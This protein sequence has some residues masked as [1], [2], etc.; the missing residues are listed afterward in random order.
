MDTP[1]RT[2]I[3]VAG[4]IG[5]IGQAVCRH[6]AGAYR[7]IG[8]T[9]RPGH[10]PSLPGVEWRN[11]DLFSMVECEAALEGVDV[12]I[13]LVHSL[14]PSAQL[15]Q[16]TFQDMDLILADNFARAAKKCG[17]SRILYLGGLLP[18]E[19]CEHLSRHLESRLEVERA[20]GSRG[21]PLT[22]LRASIVIGAHGSSFSIFHTLVE[23]LPLIPCP[24]WGR[25]LTQ[26]VALRDVV[27]LFRHCLEHPET[28]EGTFDV[29]SPDV[30]TYRQL[31]ERTAEAM[32][33]RRG[34]FDVPLK[35]SL[36]CK[37]WLHT[38]TGAPMALVAPLVE[39]MRFPMVARDRRLQEAAAIP[40]LSLQEALAEALE[41]ER[42]AAIHPPVAHPAEPPHY[43]VRSVQ[44]LPLPRGFSARLVADVY[45][46]WLPWLFRAVLRCE[47]DVDRDVR[48]SIVLPGFHLT[49]LELTFGHEY[50][51]GDD[52]QVYFITGGA[53]VKKVELASRRPRLEFREVL[54]RGAIILALHDFRPALPPWLYEHTQALIHV[55][56][57]H[58]FAWHL[59]RLGK[60]TGP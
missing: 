12:G 31:L 6:L 38:I 52:R 10:T 29:G 11:C 5:Y 41:A 53:L 27:E 43:D 48:I 14:I 40:G 57:T 58:R 3:A 24:R 1:R 22:A 8:L 32:G 28:T 4:A 19:P 20:L 46:R 13:Y 35:G 47:E 25:S 30:L 23:R 44:R 54:D 55:F 36:M 34:F 2:T 33:V 26:P 49:L 60:R 7:V 18:E 59:G 9:R 37:L 56:V 15:T 39:S 21:V 42:R 51:P 16:G 50:S 45:I 17:L